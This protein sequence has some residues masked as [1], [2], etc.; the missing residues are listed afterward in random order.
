LGGTDPFGKPLS[1]TRLAQMGLFRDPSLNPPIDPR[2][3]TVVMGAFKTPSLRNVELT[4][5]YFHNGGQGT[6]MQVVEFYNRGGDFGRE[7]QADLD[8]GIRRLGLTPDG[9]RALVAF[10]KALTDERVRREQAPFDH[11][12]I[13]VPN[14]HPG[15]ERGV[16]ND[17]TG[18]A[19]DALIEVPA[20]GAGGGDR[21]LPVLPQTD[22]TPL[23]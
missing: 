18:K 17:G 9:K 20:V 23:P 14:G 19:T 1:E 15:D 21:L 12:Q 5:P 16:T 22:L 13:F 2:E 6:L 7:N 10:L 8:R 3:R 4:G 11:P